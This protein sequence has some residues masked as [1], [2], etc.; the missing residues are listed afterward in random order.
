MAENL[1]RDVFSLETIRYI[2]DRVSLAWPAFSRAT[3]EAEAADGF[4][5]LSFGDRSRRITGS[6]ARH[7][8]DEFRRAAEILVRSLG[9]EPDAED[10]SG[11]DGFY[12]MPLAEFVAERGLEDL[13]VALPALYEMTKRFTAEG[14]I[15]PFLRRYPG[16]TLAFLR[17]LTT[18]PSPF[19]RRLAS[20]GTR[21]RLPLAGRLPQ[22]Q[23]DPSP[24]IDL[25]DRLYADPNL[26][27]RR[28]VANNI[29]DI[30]KDNPDVAV[31]TLA[32]WRSERPSDELEWMIRHGLRTLVKQSHPGALA[33][34]GYGSEELTVGPPVPDRERVVLGE[35]LAFRWT[36]RSTAASEQ[37]LLMN[38]II[39]FM[40]ANGKN[41]EKVFRLPERTLGPGEV[42]AIEKVHK[43]LPFRNQSFYPGTHFLQ[44][45]VNGIPSER[46]PFELELPRGGSRVAGR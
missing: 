10:L 5:H 21:P 2:A 41:K 40:K 18:N 26:M 44:V 14:A 12:I 35:S 1:F 9:P 8:P 34:L 43:F 13:D 38:Y 19:A 16:K 33:L 29:N 7:L 46:I 24:V 45:E 42:L 30:A 27:V 25:L 3:F 15:R 22:F 32:R 31:A 23:A 17:G 20:E 6:L 37:P 39:H 36:V 11:T 4:E 28:S